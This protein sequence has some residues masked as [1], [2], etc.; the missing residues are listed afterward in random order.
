MKIGDK[1]KR[2]RI[3]RGF[4]QAQIAEKLNI[5]KQAYSQLERS[6]TKMDMERLEQ[7]ADA[8]GV[9]LADIE[10]FDAANMFNTRY[11]YEQSANTHGANNTN[12]QGD[13]HVT[14]N[15][16]VKIVEALEKTIIQK[17]EEINFLRKQLA[18]QTN[19]IKDLLKQK[20]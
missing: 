5:T 13:I 4:T 14:Y 10:G 18:E 15:D 6:E 7:I 16:S 20:S 11:R 1:V 2:I 17:D 19:M 8:L 12:C 9:S 3:L